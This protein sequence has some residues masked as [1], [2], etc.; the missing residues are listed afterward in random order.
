MSKFYIGAAGIHPTG[1]GPTDLIKFSLDP[2][3][4]NVWGIKAHDPAIDDGIYI[5]Y[6]QSTQRWTIAVSPGK[7]LQ[8]TYWFIDTATTLSNLTQNIPGADLPTRSVLRMSSAGFREPGSGA[9]RR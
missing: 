7:A 5:G 1:I 2:A 6:D 9:W 4:P 3:D 8:Q